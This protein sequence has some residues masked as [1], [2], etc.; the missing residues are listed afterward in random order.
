MKHLLLILLLPLTAIGQQPPTPVE[1]MF[2]NNRLVLQMSTNKA[3]SKSGKFRFF[4]ATITQA[5][6]KNTASETDII[7]NNAL[8]Y[9]LSKTLSVTSGVLLHY[10]LGMVPTAGIKF[11][12]ATPGFMILVFPMLDFKP[13]LAS[14]N[15]AMLEIKPSL[16]KTWRLYT[17]SQLLYIQNLKTGEHARSGYLV[18]AGLSHD[19]FSFG[20]GH[21]WDFYGPSRLLKANTGIF[22]QARL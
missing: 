8:T 10:K 16:G 7:V 22:I 17:R 5:D 18:R 9:S 20:L 14:E 4:N 19:Q 11:Q 2:G 12:K 3:I 6:Y 21:N 1:A 15:L 13:S